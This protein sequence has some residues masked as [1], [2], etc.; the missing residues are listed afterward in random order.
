MRTQA[1]PTP[2]V[3]LTLLETGGWVTSTV[4]LCLGGLGSKAAGTPEGIHQLSQGG[5]IF[6]VICYENTKDSFNTVPFP[7][8][9]K[10]EANCETS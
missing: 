3:L 2:C 1:G 8:G 5:N 4:C 7:K 10:K 6:R 9:I